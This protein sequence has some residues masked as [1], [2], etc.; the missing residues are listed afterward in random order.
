MPAIL[1]GAAPITSGRP[2]DPVSL[3]VGTSQGLAVDSA[4]SVYVTGDTY[5][6]DFPTKNPYQERASG[7]SDGR[8][9]RAMAFGFCNEIQSGWQFAGLFHLFGRQ[10]L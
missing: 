10:R 8:P 7:K 6:I 9:S 5:S 1:P 2:P 4:G 3:Q